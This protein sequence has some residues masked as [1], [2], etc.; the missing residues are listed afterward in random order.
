MKRP[1]HQSR[2]SFRFRALA[3]LLVLACVVAL[4]A[5]AYWG[6]VPSPWL[7]VGGLALVLTL[8]LEAADDAD[9]D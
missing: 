3:I 1:N 2:E 6:L 8:F 7:A 4:G 9:R 5:G